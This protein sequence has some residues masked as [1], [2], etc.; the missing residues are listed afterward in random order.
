MKILKTICALFL[1]SNLVVSC[2]TDDIVIEEEKKSIVN[3]QLTG[4]DGKVVDET[5][6]G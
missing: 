5:K 1:F 3:P 2:T 4:D 6:K